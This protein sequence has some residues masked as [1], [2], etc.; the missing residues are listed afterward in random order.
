MSGIKT[1]H[2]KMSVVSA[3]IDLVR[4]Q[5]LTKKRDNYG[6]SHFSKNPNR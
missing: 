4:N 1:A 3:I 5:T 6:K 2:P